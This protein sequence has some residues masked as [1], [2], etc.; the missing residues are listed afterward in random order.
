MKKYHA[1]YPKVKDR[2][3]RRQWIDF[4]AAKEAEAQKGKPGHRPR[5]A[6]P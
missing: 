5:K 1:I 6:R 2:M 4:C 3:T